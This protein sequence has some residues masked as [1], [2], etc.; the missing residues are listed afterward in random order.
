MFDASDL[1]SATAEQW[2]DLS[3]HSNHALIR[4]NVTFFGNEPVNPSVPAYW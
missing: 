1:A 3:G 2:S 4:G